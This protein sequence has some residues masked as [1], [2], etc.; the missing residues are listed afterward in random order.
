MAES[1][2][3]KKSIYLTS[4]K[5]R[6]RLNCS[7]TKYPFKK[8]T[9]NDLSASHKVLSPTSKAIP[10]TKSLTHGSL[11]HLAN[12]NI[13]FLAHKDLSPSQ[14][15]LSPSPGVPSFLNIF[16]LHWSPDSESL[17]RLRWTHLW[18]LVKIKI[19][20]YTLQ[21]YS[22]G[23]GTGKPLTSFTKKIRKY[24]DPK[25]DWNPKGKMLNLKALPGI[26]CNVA[27]QV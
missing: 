26:C 13:L 19:K 12:C 2:G 14:S 4:R 1:V 18:T 21:R 10:R 27:C 24:I 8:H 25:Q 16:T 20:N 15:A 17:L 7:G 3:W 9:H 23:T 22:N 6:E 5:Q 11:I